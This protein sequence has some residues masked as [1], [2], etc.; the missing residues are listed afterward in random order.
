MDKSR[1]YKNLQAY[2]DEHWLRPIKLENDLVYNCVSEENIVFEKVTLEPSTRSLE[3]LVSNLDESFSQRLM[4]LIDEKEMTDVDAYK[5][6][7]IDRRLF[8]KIRSNKH[9]RPSKNTVLSFC[10]GLE[11]NLDEAVDLLGSAG[12]TLSSSCKSDVVILY[13]IENEIY[14][15]FEINQALDYFEEKILS[16]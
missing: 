1:F 2:L 13:F 14:D 7:H 4:R 5:R 9:Y 11:L 10:I 15:L 8:S 3:D 16:V 6:A 12:Y